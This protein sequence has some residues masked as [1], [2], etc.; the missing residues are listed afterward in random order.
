MSQELERCSHGVALANHCF[1]CAEHPIN[2]DIENTLKWADQPLDRVIERDLLRKEVEELQADNAAKN[3]QIDQLIRDGIGASESRLRKELHKAISDAE[4]WH[5]ENITLLADRDKFA[6]ERDAARASL[7]TVTESLRWLVNID[8][9]ISKYGVDLGP[10]KRELVDAYK[11]AEEVLA[12][13]SEIK[14]TP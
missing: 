14:G 2:S 8:N 13:L 4:E 6:Q 3:G 7:E 12:K 10:T 5:L 9:D 1:T 11:N